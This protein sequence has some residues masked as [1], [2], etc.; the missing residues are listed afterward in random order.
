M[1][2][3]V[4]E[5][6]IQRGKEW[7]ERRIRPHLEIARR[8]YQ[9]GNQF[10]LAV[11]VSMPRPF[12]MRPDSMEYGDLYGEPWYWAPEERGRPMTAEDLGLAI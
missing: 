4:E 10:M 12:P 8:E 11:I 7:W 2:A 5:C 9:R 3:S 6:A 1:S